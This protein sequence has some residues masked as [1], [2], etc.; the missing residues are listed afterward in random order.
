MPPDA[1]TCRGG[2]GWCANP[3]PGRNFDRAC[4][5]DRRSS[6]SIGEWSVCAPRGGSTAAQDQT[7]FGPGYSD[8]R[9]LSWVSP[10]QFMRFWGKKNL[11]EINHKVSV[12]AKGFRRLLA[13][14]FGG[15]SCTTQSS[16]TG[17]RNTPC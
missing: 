14:V 9:T 17:G 2:A 11:T 12:A 3:V 5:C 6:P 8:R 7:F 13:S 10:V 4:G 16:A 1:A 15:K